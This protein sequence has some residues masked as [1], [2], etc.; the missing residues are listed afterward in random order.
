GADLTNA[1]LTS[2]NVEGA[3]L[4]LTNL[5]GTTMTNVSYSS[6][7][8]FPTGFDPVAAGMFLGT[9][10]INNGLAPQHRYSATSHNDDALNGGRIIRPLSFAHQPSIPQI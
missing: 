5:T 3:S 7:T 10:V 9:L 8:Q 2:A 4:L 1:D 6:T